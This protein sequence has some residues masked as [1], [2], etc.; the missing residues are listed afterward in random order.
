M[1]STSCARASPSWR[2]WCTDAAGRRATAATGRLPPPG[3]SGGRDAQGR[4]CGQE[5]M[6]SMSEVVSAG[7]PRKALSTGS[8]EEVASAQCFGGTQL[9]LAHDSEA[10]GTRMRIGVYLPPAAKTAPV[11][12]VYYLFGLT[13]T[14]ARSEEHTSELQSLIRISY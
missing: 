5:W 2:S 10:T 4:G 8:F 11:P 13:C 9:T 12:A 7:A 6:S 1:S 3:G 14:E